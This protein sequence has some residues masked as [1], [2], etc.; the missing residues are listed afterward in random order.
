MFALV[1][2]AER[3]VPAEL[4]PG[5][6]VRGRPVAGA[7]FVPGVDVRG[8]PVARA[9]AGGVAAVVAMPEEIV[10]PLSVGVFAFLGL[11][12]PAGLEDLAASAGVLSI[13]LSDGRVT[14]NGQTLGEAQTQPLVAACE[15]ILEAAANPELP[16]PR[17]R[18]LPRRRSLERVWF[19]STFLPA[20]SPA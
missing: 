7:A 14:F 18:S 5:F 15:A 2:I 6:D 4:A 3:A 19:C 1:E 11:T 9:D 20:F 12:P 17:T 10:I 13:R 16:P 8:R